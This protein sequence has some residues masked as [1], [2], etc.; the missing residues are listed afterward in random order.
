MRGMLGVSSA[1]RNASSARSGSR[2]L[3][4]CDCLGRFASLGMGDG[5]HVERVVVVRLLVADQP[6]VRERLV[7][8]AAVDRERRG[9]QTLLGGL[10]S[11]LFRGDLTFTDAEVLPHAFV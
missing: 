5:E 11:R 3:E 10:G 9:I 2:S 6:E 8:A 1:N 4:V 7:V